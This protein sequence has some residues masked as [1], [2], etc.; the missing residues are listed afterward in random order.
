MPVTSNDIVNQ[1]LQMMGDN[2]P[3]VTGNAPGFDSSPAGKAAALLYGPAVAFVAR[4][5]E[6]DFARTTLA[7]VPSGNVAPVPWAFEYLYPAGAVQVWQLRPAV[8]ADANDPQPTTW[9]RA[10]AIVAGAQAPVIQTNLA[11]A[12]AIYNNNPTPDVWDPGFR[13]AVMRLL[14]SEFATALA[15]RPDT[16]SLL[17]QSSGSAADLARLRDS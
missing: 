17:L 16:A 12:I 11:G 9:V 13:E 5:W 1:A 8:V 2:A 14:A 3:T 15:G 10:N 4:E 6:W 7:L